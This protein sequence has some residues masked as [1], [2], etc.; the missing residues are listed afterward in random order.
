L[1][2]ATCSLARFDLPMSNDALGLTSYRPRLDGLRAIAVLAVLASHF[3]SGPYGIGHLGVRLFFVLS[4]YLITAQV[5][6]MRADAHGRRSPLTE[7]RNFYV[8]RVLR[9]WPAYFV[10]LSAAL[11]GN[12]GWIRA[13]ASW[14]L[15]FGSNI[16]FA[17]RDAYVPHFTAP[18]WSLAVEEQFYLLWPVLMIAPRRRL[19]L[20][21]AITC[22]A[23]A[24]LWR[25]GL[26]ETGYGPETVA[27]W[28][29]LPA[30]LD[31]L[32]G[33]ALLAIVTNTEWHRWLKA[34]AWIVVIAAP[35][36]YKGKIYF[37]GDALLI[38][39]LLTVPLVAIVAAATSKNKGGSGEVLELS[40]LRFLGKISY[41]I[42]LYHL[43]VQMGLAHLAESL[44]RLEPYVVPNG[45]WK[46]VICTLAT[47]GAA[48]LSWFC[49]ELP[50]NRL[51]R[52]FPLGSR[53]PLNG[54]GEHLATKT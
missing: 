28:V 9:L 17:V 4:G 35:A 53:E 21:I 15:L 54:V 20:P 40:P 14:H 2:A 10:A 45:P 7:L 23:V 37:A 52:Y 47:I 29:L 50:A 5:L 6:R 26:G 33:G 16:L 30:S 38:E 51:K 43:F 18:W 27:Y 36:Y 46:F 39:S 11:I 3:W 22:I 48:S 34:A 31:A 42:Y 32:A 13:V 12:W 1:P 19:I 49:L 25:L 24:A 41:G 44:P 8:R